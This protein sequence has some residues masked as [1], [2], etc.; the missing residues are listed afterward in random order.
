VVFLQ[1]RESQKLVQAM[2]LCRSINDKKEKEG[3][4]L[5]I[6]Q[7]LVSITLFQCIKGHHL[8]LKN[9]SYVA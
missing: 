7:L 9:A 5:Y 4:E 3:K 6:M 8:I 1:S 2:K